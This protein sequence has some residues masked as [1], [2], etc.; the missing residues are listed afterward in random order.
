MG[1][2]NQGPIMTTPCYAAPEILNNCKTRIDE[3]PD[4]FSLGVVNLEMIT[5]IQPK[6]HAFGARPALPAALP[7]PL[8]VVIN[9]MVDVDP[10]V[11]PALDH[12]L[13]E[14]NGMGEDAGLTNAVLEVIRSG[15]DQ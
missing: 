6:P 10:A 7:G 14:L 13:G 1:A 12:V 4:V 15:A 3:K 9:R 2:A 5:L 8:V 11:R